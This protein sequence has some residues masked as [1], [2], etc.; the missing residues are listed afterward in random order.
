MF[1]PRTLLPLESHRLSNQ[2]PCLLSL[3]APRTL[4]PLEPCHLLAASRILPPL[5]RCHFSNL[6]TS[7]IAVST[8]SISEHRVHIYRYMGSH[9]NLFFHQPFLLFLQIV[10]CLTTVSTCFPFTTCFSPLSLNS[11]SLPSKPSCIFQYFGS[12]P[13]SLSPYHS[14]PVPLTTPGIA[15]HHWTTIRHFE[16]CGT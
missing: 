13:C 12:Q 2:P 1:P 10:L 14:P 8:V 9:N 6:A 11:L 5:E 4:P 7:R 15:H 3:A 16:H